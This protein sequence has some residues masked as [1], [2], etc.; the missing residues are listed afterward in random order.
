LV[1]DQ[2]LVIAAADAGDAVGD[3]GMALVDVVG[4][5]AGGGTGALA[6]RNGDG[7]TVSQAD[8]DRAAGD[9][10]TYCSGVN[11]SAA[12]GHAGRRRQRH[13]SGVLY[14]G[15][16]GRDRCRVG[17]QVFVIATADAGDAVGDR[18]VALID[19]IAH[20]TRGGTGA[21]ADRDGDGLAV[22]QADYDR[23]ASNRG[24]N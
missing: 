20:R 9:G 5:G 10:R 11:D 4:H 7:L 3:R 16:G 8:Y 24:S 13:R 15:D 12:F 21:L 19:V 14:V 2:V 6:D 23:T 18:C 17:N 1:C 22:G